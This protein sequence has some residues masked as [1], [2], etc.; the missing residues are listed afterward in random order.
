MKAEKIDAEVE[1]A[2]HRGVTR[3]SD[4]ACVPERQRGQER[5]Y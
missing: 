3:L 1:M 5:R 4:R 2:L